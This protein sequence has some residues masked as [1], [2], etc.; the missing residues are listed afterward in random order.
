MFFIPNLASAQ[1]VSLSGFA[2]MDAPQEPLEPGGWLSFSGPTYNVLAYS[3]TGDLAGYAWSDMFGWLSFNTADVAG[4]PS[5]PCQPNVNP[6]TGA[7]TGWARFIAAPTGTTDEWNGWVHLSGS[8]YGVTYDSAT[9]RF[10]GYAW[11]ENYIGWIHFANNA[12]C[13]LYCVT[14]SPLTPPEAGIHIVTVPSSASWTLN[15]GAING[16]G[17]GNAT[18]TPSQGGTSYTVTPGGAPS[19]YDYPPTI[20]NSQGGG[21]V[22]LILPNSSTTFTI[23]YSASFNYSL[24]N[25]GNVSVQKAGVPQSGQNIIT[26]TNTAGTGQS[27]SL[28]ASGLP[29]G[30]SIGFS[31][32]G[33]VPSPGSPCNFTATITVQP[34]APSGTYSITITGS[35]LNRTTTFDLVITDS[36]NVIVTCTATP[37][38]SRVGDDVTWSVDFT[39]NPDPHPPYTYT[40]AGNN[41]PVEQ[42]SELTATQSFIMEYSTTGSK[43][44]QA[45]VWDNLRNQATCATAYINI[46]VNPDFGEF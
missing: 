15:P 14:M 34:A 3:A 4:C 37:S 35:P 2:W 23:I 28:S 46:G 8:N 18:V 45:T 16:T 29:S 30:T 9:E 7:V 41:V 44:I 27:V 24:S 25:N 22:A 42:T 20:T 6:S 31:N 11:G 21:G 32:Q 39:N 43:Q 38:S 19:G 5:A 1:T 36:P 10:G 40:W 17:S 33:C 26:A 13:S 12:S